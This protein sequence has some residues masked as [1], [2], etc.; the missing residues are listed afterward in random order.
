VS[1]EIG[2]CHVA[3]EDKGNNSGVEADQKQ[4]TADQLEKALANQERCQA[5]AWGCLRRKIKKFLRPVLDEKQCRHDP[6][7]R[8]HAR[9]PNSKFHCSPLFR[10]SHEDLSGPGSPSAATGSPHLAGRCR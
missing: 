1:H 2:D 7:H 9:R 3:G 10:R 8:Q 5:R 4:E 6:Q